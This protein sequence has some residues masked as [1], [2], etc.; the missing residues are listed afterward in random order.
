MSNPAT[1][2]NVWAAI[3]KEL[4]AVLG[5]VTD[6]NQSRT[7]GILYIVNGRKFYIG[8]GIRSWKARHVAKNPFVSLTI[9]IAKRIPVAPWIKIPQATITCSGT[10]KV[11]PGDEAPA[12]LLKEVFRHK[13]EDP[14]FMKDNCLIEVIPRGDF[15]TYGIGI[16]L[17]KMSQPELSRGRAPVD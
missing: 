4:F 9:P 1:T 5:M 7:V 17:I 12:G 15:I 13:A 16:P 6:Q 2:E 3:N 10:A 11:I 8:T 14:E